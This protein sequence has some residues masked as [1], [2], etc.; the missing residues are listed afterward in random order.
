MSDEEFEELWVLVDRDGSGTIGIN[1]V[2]TAIMQHA[3]STNST[4]SQY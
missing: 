3:H 1:A 2:I 4:P